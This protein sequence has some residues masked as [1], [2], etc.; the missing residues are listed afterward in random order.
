MKGLIDPFKRRR[1]L[2]STPFFGVGRF[3]PVSGN[4]LLSYYQNLLFE[5][6]GYT[7]T[8][9]KTRINIANQC[10]S[11]ING[12]IIALVVTRF[13]RRWMFMLSAST[14][15]LVFMSMTICFQR[16]NLAK[17]LNVENKSA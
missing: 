15:M 4:T 17:T 2:G 14:M 8:Y 9:A 5:L 1:D 7:S 6:M 16:L 3:G 12:V 13:R 11:L 10:W